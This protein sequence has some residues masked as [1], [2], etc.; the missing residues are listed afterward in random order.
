MYFWQQGT[1]PRLFCS[2][3]VRLGH[4]SSLSRDLFEVVVSNRKEVVGIDAFDLY[5]CEEK[6]TVLYVSF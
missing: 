6:V 4:K 1:L 2:S 5:S 3:S